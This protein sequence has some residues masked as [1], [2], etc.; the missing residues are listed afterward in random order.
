MLK[1]AA[2]PRT[3][4]R[5]LLIIFTHHRV[6]SV[7]TNEHKKEQESSNSLCKF[8]GRELV[9]YAPAGKNHAQD[10]QQV[11]AKN[12]NNF[13][14]LNIIIMSSQNTQTQVWKRQLG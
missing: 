14:I 10:N 11:N 4:T 9:L 2:V 13:D 6:A 5:L 1:T 3:L 8:E 7:Y 12:T